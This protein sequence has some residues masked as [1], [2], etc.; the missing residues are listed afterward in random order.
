MVNEEIGNKANKSGQALEIRFQNDLTRLGIPYKRAK[1]GTFNIDF[2]LGLEPKMHID[3]KNLNAGG[4]AD[5]KIPHTILKYSRRYGLRKPNSETKKIYILRG[6]KPFREQINKSLDEI[7]EFTGIETVVLT[8]DEMIKHLEGKENSS[9]LI[10][11]F[12]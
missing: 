1:H 8:Y 9:E 6:T 7:K 10:D 5:E 2:V 4:T 12:F 3:C 11:K